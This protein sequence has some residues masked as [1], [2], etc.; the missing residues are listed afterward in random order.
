MSKA[1]YKVVH[2]IQFCIICGVSFKLRRKHQ[3]GLCYV[4]RKEFYRQYNKN[5]SNLR[6]KNL[7]E[8]Q[9]REKYIKNRE[10]V[11]NNIERRRKIALNSYFR[12]DKSQRKQLRKKKYWKNKDIKDFIAHWDRERKYLFKRR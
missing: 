6:Y 7:T 5:D 9:Y 2:I 11:K 8:E 4:C 10:W 12:K 3:L 1:F